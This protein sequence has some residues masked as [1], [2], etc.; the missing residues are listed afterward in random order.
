MGRA[1][2]TATMSDR[3][4]QSVHGQWH[5]AGPKFHRR[6]ASGSLLDF[7]AR[8]NLEQDARFTPETARGIQGLELWQI[9]AKFSC[10]RGE[11]GA[12]YVAAGRRA[13]KRAAASPSNPAGC[14]IMAGRAAV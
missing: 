9:R 14:S 3:G 8:A 6:S 13:C 7:A 10:R 5:P 1:T 11:R 4:G 2:E 12:R